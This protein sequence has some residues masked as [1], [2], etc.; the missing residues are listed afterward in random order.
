FETSQSHRAASCRRYSSSSPP[1]S[2]PP[3]RY[4]RESSPMAPVDRLPRADR[5]SQ[6]VP[7]AARP[8]Q[9]TPVAPSWPPRIIAVTSEIRTGQRK[10]L[11]LE[12][13][14]ILRDVAAAAPAMGLQIQVLNASTT[15]EIDAAFATLVSERS[16]ALFLA[17]DPF[18]IDRR[19]QL[20]QLAA[21]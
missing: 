3:P 9:R 1:V 7:P 18:L 15:R 8:H 6:T 12:A 10:E 2:A 21:R 5:L 19:V 11:F 4:R 17:N 16:D 14:S 13:P 20:A